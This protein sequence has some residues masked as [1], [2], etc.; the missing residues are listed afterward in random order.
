M[1]VEFIEGYK[2]ISNSSFNLIQLMDISINL[3]KCVYTQSIN[4]HGLK[5]LSLSPGSVMPTTSNLLRT[6]AT[7]CTAV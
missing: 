5:Q 2:D 6:S 1:F 7:T 3:E 4:Y